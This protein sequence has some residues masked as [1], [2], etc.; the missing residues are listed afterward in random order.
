MLQCVMSVTFLD[1]ST[2]YA[3]AVAPGIFFFYLRRLPTIQS[4]LRVRQELDAEGKRGRLLIYFQVMA[5]RQIRAPA[6]SND[7][8]GAWV[9]LAEAAKRNAELG[10]IVVVQDGFTGAA[11]RAAV[12]TV[13][14]LSRGSRPAKVFSNVDAAAKWLVESLSGRAGAPS[15]AEILA[16]VEIIRAKVEGA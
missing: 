5:P 12:S 10:A 7:L 8:Q 2:E 9:R 14:L 4:L 6:L 3:T 16:A 1:T 13:L 15:E 11:I